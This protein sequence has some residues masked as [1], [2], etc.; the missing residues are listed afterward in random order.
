MD[1]ETV[2]HI[3]LSLAAIGPDAKEAV[4]ALTAA[5]GDKEVPIQRLAAGALKM[6]DPKAEKAG[7]R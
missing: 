4:P 6:I 3:A 5:L 7:V 2:P 1:W